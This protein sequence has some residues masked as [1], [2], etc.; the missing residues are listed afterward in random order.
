M[1]RTHMKEMADLL[2]HQEKCSCSRPRTRSQV[3]PITDVSLGGQSAGQAH[4]LEEGGHRGQG[5]AVVPPAHSRPAPSPA[6]VVRERAASA[7]ALL[8]YLLLFLLLALAI[9]LIIVLAHGLML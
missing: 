9:V 5:Q 1:H 6:V 8:P 3:L 2:R 4:V 7:T